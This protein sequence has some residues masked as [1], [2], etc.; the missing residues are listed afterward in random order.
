MSKQDKAMVREAARGMNGADAANFE[1]AVI[2]RLQEL[3]DSG[4]V[5]SIAKNHIRAAMTAELA[6]GK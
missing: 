2:A 6:K 1:G 4:V 5:A 3:L